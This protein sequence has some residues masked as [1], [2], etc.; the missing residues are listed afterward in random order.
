MIY[1]FL[2]FHSLIFRQV[3]GYS[4]PF[5]IIIHHTCR[6]IMTD[7]EVRIEPRRKATSLMSLLSSSRGEEDST[8]GVDGGEMEIASASATFFPESTDLSVI[9]QDRG[10][11]AFSS[12]L[13]PHMHTSPSPVGAKGQCDYVGPLGDT[14]STTIDELKATVKLL[15]AESRRMEEQMLKVQRQ[16]DV[17]IEKYKT[18]TLTANDKCMKLEQAVSLLTAKAE[19]GDASKDE[20]ELLVVERDEL[21]KKADKLRQELEATKAE[22]GRI[23]MELSRLKGETDSKRQSWLEEKENTEKE[24]GARI[25]VLD[26]KLREADN[27]IRRLEEQVCFLRRSETSQLSF[28]HYIC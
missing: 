9:F 1:N 17:Q 25:H 13:T 7:A 22:N 16:C 24:Y 5:E 20:I 8:A 21:D 26:Q 4:F 19:K 2:L 15:Q 6:G 27:Q 23:K 12:E 18:E 28:T 3:E 11:G 14:S 10:G